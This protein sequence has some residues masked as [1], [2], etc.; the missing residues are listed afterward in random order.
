[1]ETIAYY[2]ISALI[3]YAISTL[4]AP[5][6]VP[7]K[8]SAMEDFDFPQFEDGTPQCVFF[9]DCWTEDWMILGMGNFRTEEI[10]QSGGGK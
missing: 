9:G 7:P 1:M 8:A 5:R 10:R 3:S 4:L 2:I 6:P